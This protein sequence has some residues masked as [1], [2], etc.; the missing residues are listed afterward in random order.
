MKYQNSSSL[1]VHIYLPTYLHIYV[2]I[3]PPTYLP[4]YLT[5]PSTC[6]WWKLPLLKYKQT[7]TYK[8]YIFGSMTIYTLLL[9]LILSLALFLLID[10]ILGQSWHGRTSLH[11]W[12]Y[13][14]CYY[15][16]QGRTAAFVLQPL[17]QYP[18]LQFLAAYLH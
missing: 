14:R 9:T 8:T 10:Q 6:M 1:H 2:H 4:T 3:Y 13:Y 12:Y 11:S 15:G 17:T 7:Y 5:C 16:N 18:L